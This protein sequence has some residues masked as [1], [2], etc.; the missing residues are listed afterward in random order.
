MTSRDQGHRGFRTDAF[1]S[2]LVPAT[3]PICGECP[4]SI[5]T[6][7]PEKALEAHLLQHAP[8]FPC[9]K[10]EEKPHQGWRLDWDL[11]L[12]PRDDVGLFFCD[13]CGIYTGERSPCTPSISLAPLA[14]MARSSAIPR[15]P[16]RRRPSC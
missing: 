2:P 5:G 14:S 8:L 1:A 7:A 15:L 12:H 4:K 11:V 13:P 16:S 3:C 10:C 6:Q 9:Q